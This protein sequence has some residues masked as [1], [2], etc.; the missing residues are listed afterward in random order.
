LDETSVA[1]HINRAEI[2]KW[3]VLFVG[4]SPISYVSRQE[5]KGID[6]G[7]S[8]ILATI[9]NLAEQASVR[10]PAMIATSASI[11]LLRR[12]QSPIRQPEH[13]SSSKC[14]P[15]TIDHPKLSELIA[16]DKKSSDVGTSTITLLAHCN[17]SN[18]RRQHVLDIR[19]EMNSR[20]PTTMMG[21]TME[22]K[23][24]IL[25]ITSGKRWRAI[26]NK[27]ANSYVIEIAT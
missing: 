1:G 7:K 20:C 2:R 23:K 27:T 25:S 13:F 3:N 8:S 11:H 12:R 19:S 6:S 24:P 14:S 4:G 10:C 5:Q 16:A 26:Q 18:V 21:G 15:T 22:R 17:R 9:R